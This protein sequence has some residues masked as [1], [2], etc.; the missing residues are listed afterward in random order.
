MEQ[1]N[2]L[3]MRLENNYSN[4]YNNVYNINFTGPFAEYLEAWKKIT[5]VPESSFDAIRTIPILSKNTME[6]ILDAIG[7]GVDKVVE[8]FGYV[9]DAAWAVTSGVLAAAQMGWID[10]LKGEK[11]L[12]NHHGHWGIV[13]SL[14]CKGLAN[15]FEDN[16]GLHLAANIGSILFDIIVM[17]DVWN[18]L[19]GA[20]TGS[21]DNS[22]L[23]KFYCDSVRP[24]FIQGGLFIGLDFT[25][26]LAIFNA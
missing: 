22:P 21:N 10:N 12:E 25:K 4:A 6:K 19:Y 24:A 5:A 15:V 2:E 7:I 9:A 1:H 3:K 11:V 14:V 16:W 8:Y 26:L 18:H 13:G 20:F 17:D 23:H